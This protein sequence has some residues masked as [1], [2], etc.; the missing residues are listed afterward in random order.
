[1][2]NTHH[3]KANIERLQLKRKEGEKGLLQTEATYTGE[4]INFAE[5][6]KTNYADDYFVNT[7]KGHE[8]I[9]PN[10]N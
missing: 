9:R 8:T 6:L 2:Y 7:V 3:P 4:I 1:M 5:Y 10:M